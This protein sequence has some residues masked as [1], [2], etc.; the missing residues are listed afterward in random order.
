MASLFTGKVLS[1]T[2]NTESKVLSRS[3]NPRN[4][5][6]Q[7]KHIHDNQVSFP[8]RHTDFLTCP[9]DTSYHYLLFS[10]LHAFP[11]KIQRRGNSL[12]S[13]PQ[14]NK[15]L[16]AGPKYLRGTIS[17]SAHRCLSP[18][19]AAGAEAAGCREPRAA[20]HGRTC[21]GQ[22]PLP[23]Q[24]ISISTQLQHRTVSMSKSPTSTHSLGAHT[25]FFC[26]VLLCTA[27]CFLLRFSLPLSTILPLLSLLHFPDFT[28]I[29]SIGIHEYFHG[30]ISITRSPW[31]V[32]LHQ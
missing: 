27:I 3:K 12:L 17:V 2:P 22:L 14:Q 24:I 10:I 8:P 28:P 32:E 25:A 20:G 23:K 15:E 21:R 29:C 16:Y 5:Y 6:S 7:I 11:C 1:Q 4:F 13:M 18:Q 19:A 9:G 26:L 30:D 31:A